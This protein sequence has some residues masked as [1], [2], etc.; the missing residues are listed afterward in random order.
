[1]SGTG[2][3]RGGKEVQPVEQQTKTILF[4]PHDNRPTSCEQSAEAA[5]KLG[6]RVLMPPKEM[7]PL[8]PITASLLFQRLPVAAW[9][10]S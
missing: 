9:T 6:Y 3:A 2:E 5:E 10:P 1:M 8:V 7:R 4:V